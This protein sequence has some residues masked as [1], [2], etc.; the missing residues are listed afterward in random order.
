[1]EKNRLFIPDYIQRK[2]TLPQN[3][4]KDKWEKIEKAIHQIYH[5]NASNLSFQV[6]YTSGYQ[7]VLHKHGDYLYENVKKTITEYI[8]G[9][10]DNIMSF[11][12]EVFLK[13][14]LYQWERHRSAIG[15]IRDILMYLD[16]TYVPMFKKTPV[17]D[18]GIN[19]FGQEVFHQS[20]LERIQRLMMLMIYQDREGEIVLDRFLLKN[21]CQMMLEI[22]KQD[23]YLPFFEVKFLQESSEYFKKEASTVFERSTVTDYLKKVQSRLRL[24]TDRAYYCMDVDTKTKIENLVKRYMIEEFKNQLIEKDGSGCFS[25]L[26][27]WRIGDLRL[28]YDVLGL[29]NDALKPYVD[30]VR[31]F[32]TAEGVSIVTDKE[33]DEKPLELIESCIQLRRK[34]DEL[35]DKSFSKTKQGLICRD[36]EFSTAIKNS[37]DEIVNLNPRFHEYLSLYVDSKLKKGKTQIIENEFESLFDDVISLFRHLKDR[38]LFEKYYKTHLAKRLLA[39][40]SQSDE[41]EK[42]FVG[43]LKTEFGYQFTF[44]LEGMFTDMKNCK[45]IVS[46][47]KSFVNQTGKKLPLDLQVQVLTTGFWPV[48]TIVPCKV[49]NSLL[50]SLKVFSDFYLNCHSSRRLTWQYNMG[51]ADLKLNG[52]PMKYELNV[53]T[54]QMLILLLYNDQTS[55]TLL[56]LSQLT[57]IPMAV[58]KKNVLALTISNSQHDKILNRDDVKELTN[59]SKFDYNQLFTSKL[60]KVKIMPVTL[61]EP[62]IQFEETQLELDEE[63]KWA[64]DAT[65]VRTMKVR[66]TMEHRDLILECTKQ[67]Q[68]R[69]MP[70]PEQLKKRIE[71]LIE[72]EYL[73]RSKESRSKYNYLA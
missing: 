9:V 38:D 59:L 36:L 69:F 33:K 5:Q 26:Q 18:L 65:I 13:E 34:Y 50:D 40:R 7:I 12:D 10:R 35:L 4:A 31:K 47:F 22:S 53:S 51:T 29:V 56:E 52:F 41:A 2:A 72:K 32:C 6:L 1:M 70:P 37:F 45:E 64:M 73:E 3:D 15:M 23:V 55:Y 11:P 28:V 67:L 21:L 44:K 49:P 24:E 60:H 16:R 66:K 8:K 48:N 25:L 14:L 42:S 71:S 58:L 61:K 68:N 19:I 30:V 62:K 46:N 54:F 20:T 39:E 57:N 27:N 17:F 43:K 63:R